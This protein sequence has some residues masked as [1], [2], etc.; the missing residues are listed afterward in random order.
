MKLVQQRSKI[1]CIRMFM[2]LGGMMTVVFG[3]LTAFIPGFY[4]AWV[5]RDPWI[6][7]DYE[8]RME[9]LSMQPQIY[10]ATSWRLISSIGGVLG[11]I[12]ILKDDI[13]FLRL[14][15]L[16]ILLGIIGLLSPAP[17]RGGYPETTLYPLSLPASVLTFLGV[18]IMLSSLIYKSGG[19]YRL[20]LFSV[21]ILG[22]YSLLYPVIGLFNLQIY[23]DFIYYLNHEG[24]LLHITFFILGFM[25]AL[26]G[27]S[28][29]L[30]KTFTGSL[31][32]KRS[33]RGID[34]DVQSCSS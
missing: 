27:C 26:L 14:G 7:R 19:W 18:A 12:S 22:T 25:L 2:F 9:Y 8:W 24:S 16:G 28:L 20:V 6:Y 11:I 34:I 33:L 21:P 10:V 30:I 23:A 5:V 1:L 31:I 17:I 4:M 13:R 29:C 15:F 32:N 3:L